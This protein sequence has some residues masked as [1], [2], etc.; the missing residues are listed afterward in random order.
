[1]KRVL[2][3]DPNSGEFRVTMDAEGKS[4]S[5]ERTEADCAF[6]TDDIDW[7]PYSKA[8]EPAWP[9]ALA[10]IDVVSKLDILV[11]EK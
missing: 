3:I 5:I 10:L 2:W 11:K 1:M 6:S 4:V 7:V 9:Y 8:K